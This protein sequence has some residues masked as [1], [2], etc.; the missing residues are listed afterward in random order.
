[1]MVLMHR[2]ATILSN[3]CG[4]LAAFQR[5]TFALRTRSRCIWHHNLEMLVVLPKLDGA[6]LPGAPT[7][8][9]LATFLASNMLHSTLR[10]L[11]HLK[12]FSMWRSSDTLLTCCN[13]A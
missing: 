3:N 2:Y 13:A 6:S 7:A 9:R 11:S 8:H 5:H 4:A 10:F 1:M 12:V